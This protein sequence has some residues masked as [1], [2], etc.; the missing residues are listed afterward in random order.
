[1]KRSI[2][3]VKWGFGILLSILIILW[4]AIQTETVQNFIVHKITASLSQTLNTRIE[5][6]RVHI[7]FFKSIEIENIY[8]EDTKQDTLLACKKISASIGLLSLLNQTIKFD[9][10]N[11]DGLTAKINRNN[12]D[13]TFNYQFIL[14]AFAKDTTQVVP[15]SSS[16]PWNIDLSEA[17][18]QNTSFSWQDSVEHVYLKTKIAAALINIKDLDLVNQSI[19]LNHLLVRKPFVSFESQ[20]TSSKDSTTINELS[21][22]FSGWNLST[23][24]L[25]ID[26][27]DVRYWRT[28]QLVKNATFD[29]DHLD[30]ENLNLGLKNFNWDSTRLDLEL[31][32][33]NFKERSGLLL[34]HAGL[35]LSMSPEKIEV[36]DL[37]LKTPQSEI[38][39][40]TSLKFSSWNSLSDFINQVTLNIQFSNS[41]LAIQDLD[42]FLPYIPEAYQVHQPILLNGSITTENNR[43]NL[44]NLKL[45]IGDILAFQSSGVLENITNIDQI[46]LDLNLKKLTFDYKKIRTALPVLNLPSS[47]DKFDQ[48]S[49]SGIFSGGL[50]S[51]SLQNLFLN[52]SANTL[53]KATGKVNN[54]DQL[55]KLS[56]QLQIDSIKTSAEDIAYFS[57]VPLPAGLYEMKQISYNGLLSG[58]L[59]DIK[60]QGRLST[61]IGQFYTDIEI[62]FTK[63]YSNASYDGSIKIDKF[64]LGQFLGDTATLGLLNLEAIVKGNGLSPDSLDMNIDTKIKSLGFN[65][66]EYQNIKINGDID[67]LKFFG[68]ASMED[69]NLTFDFQGLIDMNSEIPIFEFDVKLDTLDLVA[70]NLSDQSIR[71]ST[72]IHSNLKG[73]DIDEFIGKA[74]VSQ[75]HLSNDTYHFYA[76]S[77][78]ATAKEFGTNERELI[79]SSDLLKATFT[80]DFSLL[81]LPGVLQNY[82]NDYF[83]V[84]QLLSHTDELDSLGFEPAEQ[85]MYPDQDMTF[86]I[87]FYNLSNF[88]QIFTPA[89]EQLKWLDLKGNFDTKNKDFNLALNI[90]SLTATGWTLD[91]VQWLIKGDPKDIIS[92]LY[93][94]QLSDGAMTFRDN[95]L[96]SVLTNNSIQTDIAISNIDNQPIFDLGAMVK[97]EDENY[98]MQFN[99][100]L[101]INNEQWN[102]PKDHQILFAHD[103]LE[104]NDFSINKDQQ[105][106]AIYTNDR[107]ANQLYTP[108]KIDFS[109]FE[110]SEFSAFTNLEG[111]KFDGL[112]NGDI[113]LND[114]TGNLHYL[115]DINVTQF[116]VNDTLIGRFDM[117]AGQ[118]SNTS[119]INIAVGLSGRGNQMLTKGTYDIETRQFD[120]QADIQQVPLILFDPFSAG[121]IQNSSGFIAGH[122]DIHGTPEL[123]DINGEL[124]FNEATTNISYLKTRYRIPDGKITIDNKLIDFGT[125]NLFDSKENTA[126]FSGVIHHDFFQDFT[127]DLKFNT[128]KFRFL[129]TS[130][131]DNELF[132]GKLYLGAKVNIGGTLALPKINIDAKTLPESKISVSAIVDEEFA[133]QADYVIYGK[134]GEILLD[135]IL[136][137]RRLSGISDYKIDLSLNLNLTPDAELVVVV[138]PTTGDQ[139][140][141]KGNANLAVRMSPDGVVGV[142]GIYTVVSGAYN[143]NYQGLVKRSFDIQPGSRLT[144]IGDPLHTKFDITAAYKT[145]TSVYPL[146]SNEASLSESAYRQAKERSDVNVLLKM[147]GDI[148]LPNISFDIVFPELKSGVASIVTQKLTQLRE[149]EAELNKQVFGLL[150]LNSFVAEQS[151]TAGLSTAGENIALSSVSS[152]ISNQLNRLSDQ[153]LKGVGLI[154]D[155]ESY[156]N[157]FEGDE[158][159]STTT[160]LNVG[161]TRSVFNDRM[162]IK[163]SGVIQVDN[164]TN[165][166]A[167][168]GMSNIAE[169]FVLEYQIDKSGNYILKVFQRNDYDAFN[170]S[171]ALKTGIGITFKKSFGE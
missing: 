95:M 144:F 120:I 143:F 43:L 51:L 23:D 170:D 96:Q 66:Y 50:A 74:T 10:I 71:S 106:I 90:P 55:D 86:D 56:Y 34:S 11:I 138:D 33:L 168:S 121:A 167:T 25:Q 127:F 12:I 157:Q 4:L 134:P 114:I 125:I 27:A 57:T 76:D 93:L 20:S 116:A 102:I 3:I 13:S 89:V 40:A 126:T 151:S 79:I 171:N 85:I 49:L 105:T 94:P 108:L 53:L 30:F 162:T 44:N 112:L 124:K 22:P 35:D 52:T 62:D 145:K 69:K 19:A 68:L 1:M 159:A 92:R 37:L 160:N 16:K 9:N 133:Q 100:S 64:N 132:Y 15:S 99:D 32:N 97:T 31:A 123:P 88:L 80:G 82:V 8:A 36:K 104:I 14:N 60:T 107:P 77:L 24:S 17:T 38:T 54:I 164:G 5:I 137:Q 70:L 42:L 117:S 45:N 26:T 58:N 87:E 130:I 135:S 153:Y 47:A 131:G 146:I 73:N 21:F 103:F 122:F 29:F 75:L 63:D 72:I 128:N 91:S 129:N 7:K 136:N 81:A 110:L 147:S 101:K 111:F 148:D 6:E 166:P 139:L 154:F 46:K 152:L 28:D 141:C 119:V 41:R 48:V 169:D 155:L 149:D 18:I 67:R 83:P 150:L 140:S 113:S 2:K 115:A 163:V 142:T 158:N 39:N 61:A 65:Q 156:R 84:N 98:L 161:L 118:L 59:Q 165:T 109:N 78:L